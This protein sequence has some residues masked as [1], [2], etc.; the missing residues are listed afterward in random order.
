[1]ETAASPTTR[2]FAALYPDD[3]A[4]D[5]YCAAR[6][7]DGWALEMIRQKLT[8][9]AGVTIAAYGIVKKGHFFC[10]TNQ[11]TFESYTTTLKLADFRG[12]ESFWFFSS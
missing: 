5:G 10:K 7:E 12:I 3:P 1:M 4:A 11:N 9:L 6:A 2:G 8:R